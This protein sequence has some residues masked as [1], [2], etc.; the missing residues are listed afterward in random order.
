MPKVE[1]N[2]VNEYELRNAKIRHTMLGIEDHGIFTF[3]LDLDYGGSGQG[4][5][6]YCLDHHEDNKD[7]RPG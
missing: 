2:N 7:Y 1:R 5:G 3:V 4:A 6:M